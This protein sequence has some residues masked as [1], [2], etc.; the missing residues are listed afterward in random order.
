[1]PASFIPAPVEL[2][3]FLPE[4]ILT[5]VATLVMILEAV[6]KERSK[7]ESF[8]S[9]PRALGVIAKP[10]IGVG[11]DSDLRCTLSSA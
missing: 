6:A 4:T 1:M 11:N 9:S 8:C 7:P 2:L 3:R 5:V 10:Y